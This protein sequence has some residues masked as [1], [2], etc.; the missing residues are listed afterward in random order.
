MWAGHTGSS[1]SLCLN[2]WGLSWNPQGLGADVIW[3]L[4]QLFIWQLSIA[5]SQNIYLWPLHEAWA[6]SQHGG[7]VPKVSI[8]KAS[9]Q[10]FLF[11]LL[12]SSLRNHTVSL[13]LHSFMKAVINANPHCRWQELDCTCEREERQKYYH[14]HFLENAIEPKSAWREDR[15]GIRGTWV[16][17]PA[18][19]LISSVAWGNQWTL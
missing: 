1:L 11:R 19:L 6:L 5:V 12:W 14:G 17:I 4:I 7:Q 2:V 9:L 8:P 16:Q 15:L 3:M 10:W 13:L 18:S